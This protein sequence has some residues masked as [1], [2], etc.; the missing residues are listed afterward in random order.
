MKHLYF[1]LVLFLGL[2]TH[3]L[4]QPGRNEGTIQKD[5]I[6]SYTFL[7]GEATL[8]TLTEPTTFFRYYDGVR[9]KFEG[10]YCVL[11]G[12]LSPSKAFEEL[13]LPTNFPPCSLSSFTLP[14]ETELYVGIAQGGDWYIS[15]HK[16]TDGSD[17]IELVADGDIEKAKRLRSENWT[18]YGHR[19]GGGEQFLIKSMPGGKYLSSSDY[20]IGLNTNPESGYGDNE[21]NFNEDPHTKPPKSPHEQ[22]PRHPNYSPG[23]IVIGLGYNAK[24]TD[25]KIKSIKWHTNSSDGK[26]GSLIVNQD[27]QVDT[28]FN[29]GI[30][31]Y[32]FVS[33]LLTTSNNKYNTKALTTIPL[34]SITT[35]KGVTSKIVS[36]PYLYGT[37]LGNSLI[38]ADVSFHRVGEVGRS[39]A[40]F[41]KRNVDSN[42]LANDTCKIVFWDRKLE[43]PTRLQ[44]IKL[45]TVRSISISRYSPTISTKY[46][47]KLINICN[48]I[49][50]LKTKYTYLSSKIEKKHRRLLSS[51]KG[52]APGIAYIKFIQDTDLGELY[53][54]ED[55]LNKKIK[56]ITTL[57]KLRNFETKYQLLDS[58]LIEPEMLRDQNLCSLNHLANVYNL[59]KYL[60][61]KGGILPAASRMGTLEAPIQRVAFL[62]G[63]S[64]DEIAKR[65]IDKNYE[66]LIST[67]DSERASLLLDL[68]R[69]W[70]N[71]ILMS[72]HVEEKR[73]ECKYLFQVN[74]KSNFQPLPSSVLNT[75]ELG[76]DNLPDSDLKFQALMQWLIYNSLTT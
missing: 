1:L 4:A 8:F 7:H 62:F 57:L 63:T 39:L 27:Y 36:H 45:D 70:N 66:E 71:L 11:S 24:N 46:T 67:K 54:T 74:R 59:C 72:R 30:D 68:N 42:R 6:Q 29:I 73:K 18:L 47:E 38:K 44:N 21:K 61:D 52:V 3:L 40:H 51:Q 19:T 16:N 56:S 64:H 58:I 50:I 49:E 23:G 2:S 43:I 10:G 20:G 75:I 33:K 28:V 9:S 13:A 17:I 25:V 53:K 31:E 34:V 48:E 5:F 69:V 22:P 26:V 32:A 76:Q 55:L 14:P 41:A 12:K 15:P 37:K 60:I 65:N 35:S